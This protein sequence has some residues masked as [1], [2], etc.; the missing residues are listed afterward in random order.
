MTKS[1]SDKGLAKI[2]KDGS[3]HRHAEIS[4]VKVK[5]AHIMNNNL[6]M[7]EI[8]VWSVCFDIS[9]FFPQTSDSVVPSVS[10]K[11]GETPY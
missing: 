5:D 3:L 9:F 6:P 1:Q 10:F 8:S 7:A 2:P 11:N 4:P